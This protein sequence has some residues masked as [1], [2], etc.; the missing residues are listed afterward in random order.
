MS[1]L[2]MESPSLARSGLPASEKNSR[3][4]LI[5]S[6]TPS[7][8]NVPHRKRMPGGTNLSASSEGSGLMKFTTFSVSRRTSSSS[9]AGRSGAGAVTS[10]HRSSVSLVVPEPTN[11]TADP[12]R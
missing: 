4:S 11:C 2:A 3:L 6:T 10:N 9:P 7:N 5:D 12:P 1:W 8:R